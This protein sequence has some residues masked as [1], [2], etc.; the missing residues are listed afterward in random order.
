MFKKL[1]NSEKASNQAVCLVLYEVSTEKYL[2]MVLIYLLNIL[3]F[4]SGNSLCNVLN[5]FKLYFN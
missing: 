5:L 2:V 3:T 4:L 1:T